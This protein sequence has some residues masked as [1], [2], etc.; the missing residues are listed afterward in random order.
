MSSA[1]FR[2]KGA[3]SMKHLL[4]KVL[5]CFL[6]SLLALFVQPLTA[7]AQTGTWSATGSMITARADQTVT[8]LS[9]GEVLLTGGE[10]SSYVVLASAELYNPATGTFSATGSMNATRFDGDTATLLPNGQVLV[11][12]GYSTGYG[13]PVPNAELYD[14]ATGTF[15]ATGSMIAVRNQ[16]SAT[17]LTNGQVLLVGGC[18]DNGGSC[19]PPANAELYNPATGTFSATGSLIKCADRQHVDAAAQRPSLGRG[20]EQRRQL[21]LFCERGAL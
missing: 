10:D 6:L 8:L 12:G 14:P 9:N 13:V 5:Y 2:D 18:L 16:Y 20:R 1:A 21:R 17:L 19:E 11:A 15:S 7:N 3:I 4:E